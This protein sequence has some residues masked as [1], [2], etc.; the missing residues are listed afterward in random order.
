MPYAEKGREGLRQLEKRLKAELRRSLM[1]QELLSDEEI[2]GRCREIVASAGI[3]KELSLQEKR[4]LTERIYHTVRGLDILQE[5]IED[6]EISEIMVNGP[7]HIFIEKAGR[8]M[9]WPESFDSVELLED[10]IRR[11]VGSCNRV[12]N[13]SCPVADARLPDGS[14]INAVLPPVA[15]DGPVLTVRRFPREPIRLENLVQRGSLTEE[16]AADLGKF[17]RGRYSILISG[18]TSAGKTTFLNALSGMM[19]PGERVITI[20]DNAELCLQGLPNLVRLEARPE[21]MEGN[22]AVSIRDLIRTSLRM[23]PDRLIVGEVRGEEAQELLQAL[24]TGHS[25]SLSTIHANSASDALTRLETLTLLGEGIPLEA[26]RRQIASAIEL[27]IH[28]ERL[29]D[30]R[31]VVMEILEVAGFAGGEYLTNP[32]YRRS[33]KTGSLMKTGD[34]VRKE[35]LVRS[36]GSFRKSG[37]GGGC[38]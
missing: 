20:E 11:I 8:L 33:E 3:E 19:P 10:V 17:V 23:R 32:L 38:L 2:R 37:K 30:G 22:A 12:I 4:H 31:R 15:L 28:L 25:G 26:V 34:L 13:E 14:R 24:N 35:K 9:L 6:E 1:G 5:L 27:I 16:A 21:N 36:E 29:S 7:E 18:G